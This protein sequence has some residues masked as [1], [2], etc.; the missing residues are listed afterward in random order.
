MKVF[1]YIGKEILHYDMYLDYISQL[2][3]QLPSGYEYLPEDSSLVD[4]DVL[5]IISCWDKQAGKLALKARKMGIP[6]IVT[7]LGGISKWNLQKPFIKRSLQQFIYLRRMIAQAHA[8]IATTHQ[9]YIFL[10]DKRWNL[11]I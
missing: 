4:A 7:P 8:I 6:Y 11:D 3:K 2:K 5:H 10:M 9:E 1:L